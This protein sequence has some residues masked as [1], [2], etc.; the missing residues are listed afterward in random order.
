MGGECGHCTEP[1]RAVPWTLL[2][3]A[4][5]LSLFLRELL[6]MRYLWRT[7]LRLDNRKLLATLGNE[8]H[9]PLDKAVLATL[10][11]FGCLPSRIGGSES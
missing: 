7:R 3:L 6:E 4:A 11:S 2:S 9:T 5:S 10:V 8:P 1:I